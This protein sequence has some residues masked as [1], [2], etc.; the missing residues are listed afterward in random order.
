MNATWAYEF[1]INYQKFNLICDLIFRQ[2]ILPLILAFFVVWINA[3]E[4]SV[5]DSQWSDFSGN[6]SHWVNCTIDGETF[7]DDDCYGWI[8]KVLKWLGLGIFLIIFL[9]CGCFWYCFCSICQIC[10]CSERPREVIYTTYVY[11]T[12]NPYS[13]IP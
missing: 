4:I 5:R 6:N 12:Q 9:M 1:F 13:Q 2:L 10:C 11:P 8:E 7:Y 3:R